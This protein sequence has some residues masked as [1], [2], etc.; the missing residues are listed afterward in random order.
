[1]TKDAGRK[2]DAENQ[3]EVSLMAKQGFRD[4]GV[5]VC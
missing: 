5:E 4:G 2:A 3:E 1:M